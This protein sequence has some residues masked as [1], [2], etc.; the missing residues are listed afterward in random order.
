MESS[1]VELEEEEDDFR[2]LLDLER[3]FFD[4]ERLVFI[5]GSFLGTMSSQ[6]LSEGEGAVERR[7][8]PM[9]SLTRLGEMDGATARLRRSSLAS[10]MTGD[11]EKA[12]ACRRCAGSCSSGNGA[13][14]DLARSRAICSTCEDS[15]AMLW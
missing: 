2:L 4:L 13:L 3:R 12:T 7:E 1:A 11:S 5:L 6:E 9:K 14:A 15:L 8:R 10:T